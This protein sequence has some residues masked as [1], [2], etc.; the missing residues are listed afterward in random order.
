M[1]SNFG[2]I[3]I[4][5]FADKVPKTAENFIELCEKGYYKGTKFHR[6]IKN[7]MVSFIIIKFCRFK[8]EILKVLEKED[9]PYLVK[10]LKMNFILVFHIWV[11][12][13]FRWLIVDLIQMALNCKIVN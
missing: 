12:V 1:Q 5:I 8:E 7:F 4:E 13:F 3:A 2:P 9:N 6:L 10:N 11:E